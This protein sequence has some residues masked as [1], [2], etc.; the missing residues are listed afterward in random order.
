[1]LADGAYYKQVVELLATARQ[2]VDVCMFYIALPALAHPTHELLD[3]LAKK[4][5]AGCA[6]RVLVDQDKKDDPYRSR[7]VNARPVGVPETRGV[8]V[9]GQRH[10]PA[11]ARKFIVIDRQPVVIGSTTGQPRARAPLRGHLVD[12]GGDGSPGLGVP[13]STTSGPRRTVPGRGC[14]TNPPMVGEPFL[15]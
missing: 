14:Q 15:L 2:R 10:R 6:V 5:A 7:L 4:A 9:K 3:A 1:M 12:L 8:D 11:V 13:G